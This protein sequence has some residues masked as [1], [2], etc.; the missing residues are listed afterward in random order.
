MEN[1]VVVIIALAL[2]WVHYV[3]ASEVE[4][5]MDMGVRAYDS[6]CW[7]EKLKRF[8][9]TDS[10]GFLRECFGK[11]ENVKKQINGDDMA[12]KYFG[13]WMIQLAMKR[14]PQEY[15]QSC[16]VYL[17]NP[18]KPYPVDLKKVLND[19]QSRPYPFEGAS[20][21]L[22]NVLREKHGEKATT[23][24]FDEKTGP[25][26]HWISVFLARDNEFRARHGSPPF[27]LV[28]ELNDQAQSWAENMASKC[29][30]YHSQNDDPGRQWHGATTGENLSCGG[31]AVSKEDAAYIAS[32]GWYEE[33]QDYPFPKGFTGGP[34]FSKIG[35]FTQSVWKS[36]LYVGYGFAYNP[37]CPSMKWFIAARYGPP[38]N[39]EG[40]YQENVLPP[41]F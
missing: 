26:K 12:L 38:G 23:A 29:Q 6:I 17:Q 21:C 14:L 31:G 25:K 19:G 10:K 32:N 18:S 40:E 35:H 39:M 34:S 33:I 9:E 27:Q 30:M 16:N 24:V 11:A 1:T 2:P 22:L 8:P 4:F 36:T 5:G 20:L 37:N 7:Y 15:G 13:E 28:K 41:R 3:G